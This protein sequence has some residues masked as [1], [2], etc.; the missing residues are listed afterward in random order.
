ME[1]GA[2]WSPVEVVGDAGSTQERHT[3]GP[4]PPRYAVATL[5]GRR[6]G[7]LERRRG[8]EGGRG[9]KVV[10]LVDVEENERRELTHNCQV[11]RGGAGNKAATGEEN[12]V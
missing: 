3:R 4:A 1:R 8:V 10:K 11:R 6:Q 7:E 12:A 9:R 5:K 2:S